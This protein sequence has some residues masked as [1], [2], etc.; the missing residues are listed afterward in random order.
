MKVKLFF[1]SDSFSFLKFVKWIL[2]L[3]LLFISYTNLTAE[4]EQNDSLYF[5]IFKCRSID[6]RDKCSHG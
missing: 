6:V 2:T 5:S 3:C 4:G 1:F